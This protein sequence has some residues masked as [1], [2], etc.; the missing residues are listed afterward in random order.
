[1]PKM[2]ECRKWRNAENGGMPKMA[3]CRKWRMQKMANAENGGM[4]KMPK[5]LKAPKAPK[6]EIDKIYS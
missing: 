6:H 4:Q 2:A 1:M 3:E 5:I